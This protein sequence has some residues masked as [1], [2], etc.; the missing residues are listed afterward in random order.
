MTDGEAEY[1][2]YIVAPSTFVSK[3]QITKCRYRDIRRQRRRI[4]EVL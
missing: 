2:Q 3:R 1:I 4:Y